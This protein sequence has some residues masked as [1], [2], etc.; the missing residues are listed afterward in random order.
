MQD[1]TVD[2]DGTVRGIRGRIVSGTLTSRGYLQTT[3]KHRKK[4][5]MHRIIALKLIPNP[6]GLPEVNHINGVKTDNRPQNLEWVT[7][8]QNIQHAIK[9]RLYQERKAQI[10]CI[11]ANSL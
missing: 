2:T 6:L 4:H 11:E 8:L 9:L 7:T 5:L 3:G 10:K 1:Y